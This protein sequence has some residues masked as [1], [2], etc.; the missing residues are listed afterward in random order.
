MGALEES[1]AGKRVWVSG[2]TGFKGSWLCEWLLALD[3]DV[4][5]YS[6]GLP[7]EP[8]LFDQLGLCGRM[9]HEIGDIRDA[10]HVRTSLQ[11]CRPDFIFHLAAQPLVRRSYREPSLT[12]ETNVNGT[13]NVLEA[14]RE[15]DHVCAVVVVT[16]DKCYLAPA[17]SGGHVE[18]DALGGA[19]PYS[20]SKAAAEILV[21]SWRASFFP[22]GG[23]VGLASARAG[24]VLGG[25]DWAEDRLV[26]DLARGLVR[27]QTVVV[28]NP[29][30]TR[31]WQHV[32]DPLHG[33][34]L[35]AAQLR[36]A[37]EHGTRERR[38][39]L[40]SSFNF[41]PDPANER[42]VRELVAAALRRWPG[43][44]V[45]QPQSGAPAEALELRLNSG[46]AAEVLGWRP[47]W[48]FDA[49]V[50]RTIDWYRAV[51]SEGRTAIEVTQQQ[52]AEF[53]GANQ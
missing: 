21:A 6:L 14:V 51:M 40:G 49:A 37:L 52:L 3:A 9:R 41:G 29:A 33:Y 5:G 38:A 22:D 27:S 13:M 46:R 18:A 43:R 4:T 23:L 45:E 1:F 28:R 7:S 8:A 2:H 34:L 19:D 31:P 47:R 12:F 35:L 15:L 30:S 39:K 42:T 10:K 36:A 32:L 50:T 48:D 20:A 25:G 11:R 26:P 53:R 17:P 44:V 24:N 16:S